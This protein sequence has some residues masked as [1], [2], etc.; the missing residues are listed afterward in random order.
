MDKDDMDEMDDLRDTIDD[1]RRQLAEA[2]AEKKLGWKDA[3][4]AW[5][6]VADLNRRLAAV[7]TAKHNKTSA[8]NEELAE[9]DAQLETAAQARGAYCEQLLDASKQIA[10][11]SASEHAL[12]E[13]LKKVREARDKAI[14]MLNNL[15]LVA[16]W[17]K[18][19]ANLKAALSEQPE[20]PA[21][22]WR[23]HMGEGVTRRQVE[24]I[25]GKPMEQPAEDFRAEMRAM[26]QDSRNKRDCPFPP[27]TDNPGPHYEIPAAEDSHSRLLRESAI[28]EQ[29]EAAEKKPQMMAPNPDHNFAPGYHWTEHERCEVCTKVR[30]VPVA[31]VKP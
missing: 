18:V 29:E 17:Q 1:L 7:I 4:A 26:A 22:D 2:Q 14:A 27:E 13:Q 3:G 30:C 15:G 6:A 21:E 20:Q 23:Q 10:D 24:I 8:L 28:E 9:K 19:I 5:I 16:D 31:G 25:A 12:K 11:L